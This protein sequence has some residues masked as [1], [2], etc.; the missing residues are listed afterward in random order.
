VTVHLDIEPGLPEVDGYGGELNQVWSNLLDNAID[1]SPKGHVHITAK[2]EFGHVVVR[3]IDDGPGIPVDVLNRIFDP[4]FTTKPVG[5]GTGLGLD[6]A[7]RL[8]H[9]HQG[10]LD[11]S[12]DELGTTFRVTLPISTSTANSH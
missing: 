2:V 11:V 9:R 1:A 5:E 8:V 7:M 3:V 6:I 4:F 12:T 10:T